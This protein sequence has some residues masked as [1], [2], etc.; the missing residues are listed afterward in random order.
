MND[1]EKCKCGADADQDHTCPYREELNGDSE[2][3]CNC[4]ENCR[5]ACLMDI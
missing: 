3:L 2:T 5:R 4:C 1:D